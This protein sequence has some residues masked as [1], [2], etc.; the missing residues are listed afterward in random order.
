[1]R[2]GAMFGDVFPSLFRA[3]V[4]ER[5]PFV[6]REPPARLRGMLHWNREKCTGCG[7]CVTDCP[8]QSLEL[9]TYDKKA[10]RFVLKFQVDQCTFCGQCGVSCNQ[11]ALALTPADWELAALSR[12]P[13]GLMFGEP[14]DVERVRRGELP[15]AAPAAPPA[16]AAG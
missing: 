3:P 13:L 4:T 1:M 9:V 10:K 7:M 14:E 12:G 2:L 11:G 6:R 5:Y 8:S 16:P 15:V